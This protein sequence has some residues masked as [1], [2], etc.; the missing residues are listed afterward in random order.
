MYPSPKKRIREEGRKLPVMKR[1]NKEGIF[2]MWH[3]PYKRYH[4]RLYYN[5]VLTYDGTG[6]DDTEGVFYCDGTGKA[7]D[8]DDTFLYE[9]KFKD[10]T[11]L[12]EGGYQNGKWNG[13]GRQYRLDGTS[14]YEGMFSNSESC[15]KGR[16]EAAGPSGVAQD[17]ESEENVP[18][19]KDIQPDRSALAE[20]QELIGLDSLKREVKQAHQPV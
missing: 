15:L 3:I 5:G 11:L 14:E 7:Y 1:R 16:Q 10:G 18:C 19:S 4:K 17:K 6:Y 20:L 12:Y 9:G 13:M 8:L 2:A